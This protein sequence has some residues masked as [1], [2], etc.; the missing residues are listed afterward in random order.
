[1]RGVGFEL[2][3]ASSKP[4]DDYRFE[5]RKSS[6]DGTDPSHVFVKQANRKPQ[7]LNRPSVMDSVVMFAATRMPVT[8][9]YTDSRQCARWSLTCPDAHADASMSLCMYSCAYIHIYIYRVYFNT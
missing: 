5:R 4:Q 3:T 7:T 2:C 9:A 6:S 8:A 1:M